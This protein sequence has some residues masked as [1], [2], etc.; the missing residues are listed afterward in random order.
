MGCQASNSLW[1]S[2]DLKEFFLIHFLMNVM[3]S[4]LV[5]LLKMLLG[6]LKLSTLKE[7]KILLQLHGLWFH[8]KCGC[9]IQP[10]WYPHFAKLLRT[11]LSSISKENIKTVSQT[12]T[13]HQ[14]QV[15]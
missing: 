5:D 1:N 14:L 8:D 12:F 6:E 13:E 9:K 15:L 4:G 10:H 3:I 11:S 2:L 7:H